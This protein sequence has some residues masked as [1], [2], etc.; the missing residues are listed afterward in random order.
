MFRFLFFVAICFDTC[1]VASA[2]TSKI[3]SFTVPT[4]TFGFTHPIV[5]SHLRNTLGLR[6]IVSNTTALEVLK[7]TRPDSESCTLRLNS[8]LLSST[9]VRHKQFNIICHELPVYRGY[10]AVHKAPSHLPLISGSIP[11]LDSEFIEAESLLSEQE[12]RAQMILLGFHSQGSSGQL[13]YYFYEEDNTFR[14]GYHFTGYKNNIERYSIIIDAIDG[15]PSYL[16]AQFF[17]AH[18]GYA[19]HENSFESESFLRDLNNISDDANFLDGENFLVYGA[20]KDA[21]RAQSDASIFN[22]FPEDEDLFD[23]VQTYY[24]LERAK[25]FFD[26]Y[27]SDLD[28]APIEVYTHSLL[29]NNAMFLPGDDYDPDTIYIGSNDGVSMTNLNRDSDVVIHEYSHYIV[30]Q[31]LQATYGESLILHEGTADFFA[32]VIND[33]PYLAESILP[34]SSY[35]RTADLDSERSFDDEKDYMEGHQLGQFWSAF[36]WDFYQDQGDT[37]LTL[38]TRSLFYWNPRMSLTEAFLALLHADDELSLSAHRCTILAMAHA[39]GFLA[40]TANLDGT[41]CGLDYSYEQPEPSQAAQK[42]SL[43]C[44]AIGLNHQPSSFYW[45]ILSPILLLLRRGHED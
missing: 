38:I 39:R 12:A 6:N 15:S 36:L 40:A 33:N 5:S 4:Q 30:Y 29:D 8:N 44:G 2:M 24:S 28:M 37:A 21:E 23:Q 43:A 25:N 9:G 22:Y 42:N 3:A 26:E 1:P 27:F 13:V 32:Y 10:L 45:L 11:E 35:L 14:P 34:G 7:L 16:T 18:Q 20:D 17:H 31:F 19:Y 41:S